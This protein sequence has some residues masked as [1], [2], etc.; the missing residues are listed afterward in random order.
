MVLLSHKI[1]YVTIFN[2]NQN[3]NC[4]SGSKVT[5]IL[6]NECILP[7]GGAS[8]WR[9]C[10]CILRRRLVFKQ[11]IQIISNIL[12]SLVRVRDTGQTRG[13]EGVLGRPIALQFGYCTFSITKKDN[14]EILLFQYYS[15]DHVYFLVLPQQSSLLGLYGPVLL[16]LLGDTGKCTP[17]ARPLRRI[18]SSN[19]V[20]PG[21]TYWKY[22]L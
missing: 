7:I 8:A 5:A 4:I 10:V 16:H 9:V 12:H 15:F 2:P 3:P 18:N 20:L 11:L 21:R 6:L 22:N 14:I 19:I 13:L 17:A 1:D